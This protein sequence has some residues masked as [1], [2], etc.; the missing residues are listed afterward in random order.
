MS[1][2]AWRIFWLTTVARHAPTANAGICFAAPEREALLALDRRNGRHRLPSRSTLQDYKVAVAR[3]GGYFG[4]R[5][6]C[7]PGP[8]TI[9]RG[10]LRLCDITLG[11]CASETRCGYE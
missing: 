10:M 7:D 11:N 6:D 3:L 4:R 8:L 9:W 1:V 5:T 2:V